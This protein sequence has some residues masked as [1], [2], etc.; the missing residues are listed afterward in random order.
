[1][2][3]LH[4]KVELNKT[5]LSELRK[6]TRSIRFI[7]S[8]EFV[9]IAFEKGMLDNYLPKIKDSKKTLLDALLWGLKLNGCAISNK[10]LETIM[11]IE[12]KK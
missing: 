8:A 7:R 9:T 11:R 1:M 2:H 5:P 10:D 6:A 4:T 12:T 3:K